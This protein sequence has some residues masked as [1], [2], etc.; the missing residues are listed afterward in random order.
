[1]WTDL[2]H[3][4]RL[5]ARQPLFIVGV[6]STIGVGVAA[7]TAVF[8]TV[9]AVLLKPLPY[10]AAE[11]LYVLG[12]AMLDG[13][14]STGKVAPVEISRLGGA[15]PSIV[16]GSYAARF[17]GTLLDDRGDPAAVAMYGVG[18][19]FFDVFG[20][21]LALG[22]GFAPADHVGKGPAFAVLSHRL[23]RGMFGADANLVGRTIRLADTE[24][25]VVG[26]AAPAFDVPAGADL[27]FNSRLD[28]SSTAHRF[29]GYVRVQPGTTSERLREELAGAMAG[30]AREFPN[31]ES[32]RAYV[33]RTMLDATVGD[34]RPTLLFLLGASALVLVLACANVS[35]LMIVWNIARAPELAVR[36]VLGAERSRLTRHLFT[37]NAAIVLTGTALGVVLAY[38]GIN[39]LLSAGAARLPRLDVVPFDRTVALFVGGLLLF[40]A[41]AATLVPALRSGSGSTLLEGVTRRATTMPHK[42]RVFSTLIVAEIALAIVVVATAGWITLAFRRLQTV[43]PGFATSER[44]AVGLQLAMPRYPTGERVALWLQD[45]LDRIAA[46]PGVTASAAT[47]SFP[48]GPERDTV[49]YTARAG[50]LHDPARP[51]SARVRRVSPGYFRAMDIDLTMGR[52]LTWDDRAGAPLVA[53]VNRAFAERYLAGTDPLRERFATGFPAIVPKFTFAVVG[54]VDDVSYESLDAAPEPAFY[55]ANA[56]APS[57]S[58]MQTLVVAVRQ[59]GRE[60]AIRQIRAIVRA[61]DPQVAMLI[62]P[63]EEIVATSLTRPRL[64]MTLMLLFAV[65]ALLLAASGIYAI[66]AYVSKL[67]ANEIGVRLALG[68]TPRQVF[69]MMLRQ[70]AA[71][72][73]VGLL[74]GAVGAL[75]ASQVAASRLQHVRTVEAVSMFVVALASVVGITLISTLV[76]AWRAARVNPVHTLRP[77]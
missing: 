75:A 19:D 56:Q 69:W 62:Q 35:A 57:P 55:V 13:S 49:W 58:W 51:Q 10:P 24:M 40:V 46:V 6:I 3:S 54:V 21:P 31:E 74:L 76:P 59:D 29:D 28:P 52:D 63:V 32:N 68:A 43:D 71:L 22:R 61:A 73:A 11:R 38:G 47:S 67:R 30:L 45:V 70:G 60:E 4:L 1:M 72:A 9:N 42:R 16:S 37:E 44:V 33:A 36:A 77:E 65:L 2:K 66:T 53:V 34:L 64:A 25:M 14:A 26:V 41:M 50:E 8:S 7:T 15:L 39:L 18:K 48:L 12:T 5:L 23:W 27:W 17:D 20:L